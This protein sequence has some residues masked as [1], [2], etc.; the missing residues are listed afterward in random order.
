MEPNIVV[1]GGEVGNVRADGDEAKGIQKVED[2]QTF[3]EVANLCEVET[4]V[5]DRVWEA[6]DCWMTGQIGK[7]RWGDMNGKV[8]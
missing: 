1:E 2:C 7:G 4:N 3:G 8:G 6:G 5:D